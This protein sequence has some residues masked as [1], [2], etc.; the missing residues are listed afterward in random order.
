MDARFFIRSSVFDRKRLLAI[1][2]ESVSFEDQDVCDN[3]TLFTVADMEAF[4]YGVRWINGWHFVIGRTYFID[5]RNSSK[6]TIRIRL[7]SLYGVRKKRLEEKYLQILRALM[8]TY[9]E[10]IIDHYSG[11]LEQ[12]M[13]FELSGVTVSPQGILL[14]SRKK[15]VP[16]SRLVLSRYNDYFSLSED[17]SPEHY[18]ILTY[19][20]DWNASILL[21][22]A[23]REM[24]KSKRQKQS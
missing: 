17:R 22:V 4:R 8:D 6:Q 7:Q 2:P 14:N 21:A 19:G 13:S 23:D 3:P 20:L 5:I 24:Q 11:L 16:W 9:F 1:D 10:D 18:K 12:D 15:Q